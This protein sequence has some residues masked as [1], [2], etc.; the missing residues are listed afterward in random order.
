MKNNL[1][2]SKLCNRLYVMILK[3]EKQTFGKPYN[4]TNDF[5]KQISSNHNLSLSHNSD[6]V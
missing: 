2:Y 1:F 4:F 5:N 3:S 6:N